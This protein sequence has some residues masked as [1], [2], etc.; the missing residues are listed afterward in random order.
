MDWIKLAWQSSQSVSG[1]WRY[2]PTA[3][4]RLGILWVI[5]NHQLLKDGCCIQSVTATHTNNGL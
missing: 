3:V 5:S 2:E 1:E 4:L